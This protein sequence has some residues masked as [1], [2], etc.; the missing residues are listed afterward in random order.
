[1]NYFIAMLMAFTF[2][3]RFRMPKMQGNVMKFCTD[4][5]A[6]KKMQRSKERILPAYQK[7]I[8]DILSKLLY[9]PQCGCVCVFKENNI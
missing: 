6:W 4:F 9:C 8:V 2:E 5:C 1:M 7:I 3:N